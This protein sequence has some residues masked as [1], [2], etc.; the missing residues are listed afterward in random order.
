MRRNCGAS[1]S[2]TVSPHVPVLRPA[3]KQQ[4]GWTVSGLGHVDAQPVGVDEA[5]LYAL[6]LREVV[7]L[8]PRFA[9]SG[10]HSCACESISCRYRRN[11]GMRRARVPA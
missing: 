9:P 1:R 4:H 6:D 10:L 7:G 8:M 5:V 3:V 11:P 2:I